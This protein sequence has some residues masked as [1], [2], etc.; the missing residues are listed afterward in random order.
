MD[1]EVLSLI[2]S[3]PR[4]FEAGWQKDIQDFYAAADIFA[5]PSHREGFGNVAIEASAM[6]VP[7]IGFDVIGCRESISNNIFRNSGF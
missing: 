6:E 3:N 4:I 7:V 2:I 1:L 5:F